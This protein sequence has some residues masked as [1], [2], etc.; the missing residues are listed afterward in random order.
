MAGYGTYRE[1]VI[2]SGAANAGLLPGAINGGRRVSFTEIFNLA[3]SAVL[4][5]AGTANVVARI[6]AGHVL[7]SITV[8]STVSLGSSTL[9]FGT[10]DN[11]DAFG[12]AAA[13]GTTAEVTK[14]YLLTAQK[15]VALEEET[16]VL[17][18]A[19]SA[20]L[21]SSGTVVVEIVASARG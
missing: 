11:D 5:T 16:E 20:N 9:A 1:P 19:A 21:P 4:K 10:A 15:G 14:E 18:T 8:R 3:D 13:Y 7:Q 6:P 12:T 2:G 17:M